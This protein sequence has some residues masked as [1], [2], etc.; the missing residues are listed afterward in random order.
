MIAQ[1][2]M[3]W[4]YEVGAHQAAAATF[5][6]RP[7]L[8]EEIRFHTNSRRRSRRMSPETRGGRRWS[9][10][11]VERV[12]EH[13]RDD[14][15]QRSLK[16]RRA[17][18]LRCPRAVARTGVHSRFDSPDRARNRIRRHRLQCRT[19]GR[20]Q[21][22][23]LRPARPARQARRNGAS[24]CFANG[25]RTAPDHRQHQRWR[26]ARYQAR[27]ASGLAHCGLCQRVHDVA[28]TA[29]TARLEGWR[30]SRIYSPC[31]GSSRS[32]DGLRHERGRSGRRRRDH[33]RPRAWQRHLGGRPDI[34]GR[35]LTLDNKRYAVIE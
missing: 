16:T 20:A 17:T 7:C 10:R 25:S 2:V 13:T 14:F 27:R 26:V 34:I 28:E 23:A 31:W 35:T 1:T 24:R 6:A 8:D 12:K 4:I 30:W 3:T 15:G 22:F 18:S 33:R 11:G 21:A 32:T 9:R 5:G 29:Q 19:C